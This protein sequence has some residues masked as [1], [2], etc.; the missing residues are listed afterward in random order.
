MRLLAG[1]L[2]VVLLAACGGQAPR[3]APPPA[4]P[5][6]TGGGGASA[7]PAA[8]AAQAPAPSAPKPEPATVHYGGLGG[9]LDD[10]IFVGQAKGFFAAQ[11]I[12]V[13]KSTF[14]SIADSLPLLATNQLDAA[15]GSLGASVFNAVIAGAPVKLVSNLTV[16]RDPAIVPN[17]RSSVG[18]VVRKDLADQMRSIADLKG[19]SVVVNRIE[20][21]GSAFVFVELLRKVGLEL[22]D[23]QTESL[24]FTEQLAALA[25]G[26]VDAIV[27]VEPFITQAQDQGIGVLFGD[28][29]SGFDG[30]PVLDLFYGPAFIENRP[31]VARRFLVAMMQAERYIQDAF[32]KHVNREEAIQL[33]IENTFN[34]DARLY[35]RMGFTRKETN[36]RI[37][38]QAVHLNQEINLRL[39]F[40]RQPIDVSSLMDQS[41]GQYALQQLGPYRE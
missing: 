19:R 25:N 35:D 36:G 5:P 13:E 39:G 1:V 2:A 6:S 40:Q 15:G 18:L 23:L 12:Q 10:A 29:G 34:K 14:S 33:Y 8:P 4:P 32:V 28:L 7:G 31:D 3:A 27:T 24:A 38:V 37:N 30:Y 20:G 26:K 16:L 17:V 22:S 11:G 21:G 9:S 41:F